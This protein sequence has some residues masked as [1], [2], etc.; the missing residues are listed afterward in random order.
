M[1]SPRVPSPTALLSQLV[2]ESDDPI[3][4]I[5]H[6]LVPGGIP[7]DNTD[8]MVV[9]VRAIH[10]EVSSALVQTGRSAELVKLLKAIEEGEAPTI[11]KLRTLVPEKFRHLGNAFIAERSLDDQKMAQQRRPA[12]VT[13]QPSFAR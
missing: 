7:R 3:Q 2:A 8:P 9:L 10:P 4:T 13:G 1:S 5:R 6:W 12:V 11:R